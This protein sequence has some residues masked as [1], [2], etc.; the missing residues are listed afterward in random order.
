MKRHK[1]FVF[2]SIVA[3]AAVLAGIYLWHKNQAKTCTN[4]C[5]VILISVD[6]MRLDRMGSYGYKKY[7]TTPNF[8]NLAKKSFLFKNYFSAAYLTPVSEGAVQ[9]GLYPTTNTVK[10]FFSEVP[11][12]I[13]ILPEYMK[14]LGFYTQSIISSPEFTT[15]PSLKKGFS[16]GYDKYNYTST[17]NSDKLLFSN[18]RKYPPINEFKQAMQN[19]IKQNQKSFTWVAIGG[20][21]WPYGQDV[22]NQFGVTYY[23]G[24]LQGKALDWPLFQ[25]VYNGL[26]YP[27]QKKLTKGDYDYIN[28][29]YDNGVY[30]FDNYLGQIM[31]QL[32]ELKL[33]KK[34]IIVL[35]SEHGEGLGEHGYFAHYDIMDSQVHEPFLIYDPRLDGGKN[36][37][38]LVGSVDIL[39]TILDLVDGETNTKFQGKSVRPILE[40]KEPDGQRNEVYIERVP[41]WEEGVLQ[42]RNALVLDKFKPTDVLHEDYAI[43]TNRWK[44]ILRDSADTMKKINYWQDLTKQKMNFPPEE[45]YDIK[46]DPSEQKNVADQNPEVV[47]ELK[48][49]LL[50]WREEAITNQPAKEKKTDMV[51]PYL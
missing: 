10:S 3:L 37:E 6:S 43:R 5:N 2:A 14:N 38:S 31:Q 24:I 28:D 12:E 8:D 39:P 1:I 13:K 35:E 40:G 18:T 30:A 23:Q 7:N 42:V 4:D 21:H 26:L 19:N 11:T 33:D 48:A 51:Q 16:R 32:K 36:I 45:L 49:K 22:P 44:Y 25:N 46:S 34:T 20:V 47:R 27:D 50:K 15:Y 17:D 9:T 41:L 29:R